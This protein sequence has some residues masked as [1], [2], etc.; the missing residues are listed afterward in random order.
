MKMETVE[1]YW[2]C[3]YFHDNKPVA[4]GNELFDAIVVEFVLTVA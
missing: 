1:I 3:K 2:K 4:C